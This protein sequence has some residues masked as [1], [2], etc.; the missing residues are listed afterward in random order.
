MIEANVIKHSISEAG[1]EIVSVEV[2]YPRYIHAEL[3]THRA[4]SKNSSSSRAIPAIK[5]ISQVFRSPVGFVFWGKNQSGMQAKEE[6]TGWRLALAKFAWYSCSKISCILA[7]VA[8]L[9]GLHKQSVN[10]MLEPYSQIKVLIT[11]TDWNN[12]Y[13]LRCHEDAQPEINALATAIRDKVAASKPKLLNKGEWHLPYVK[14]KSFDD[15]ETSAALCAQVS[16]RMF[17]KSPKKIKRIV[18]KLFRSQPVHASPS[19][20]QA[21]PLDDPT[22]RDANFTGWKQYR[23]MIVD[24]VKPG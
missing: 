1:K 22:E 15:V 17:D 13:H 2:I 8:H 11:A 4:L 9:A 24:N 14:S 21:T 23:S 10:R 19:E 12:F 6:L 16:F 3:M 18:D 5:I 7:Y 20:H